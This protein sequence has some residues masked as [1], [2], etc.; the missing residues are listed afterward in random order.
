MLPSSAHLRTS[1]ALPSH[2]SMEAHDLGA[3]VKEVHRRFPTGVTIVTTSSDGKPYGL[4]VNAF[5]SIS[6]QPPVVLFCVAKTSST[7]RLLYAND[8]VVVNMLARLQDDV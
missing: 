6:I 2:Q 1:A 4:A 7:Y 5:S 8:A 3:R